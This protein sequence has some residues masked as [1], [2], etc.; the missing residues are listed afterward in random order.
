MGSSTTQQLLLFGI[1]L[2][3][4]GQVSLSTRTLPDTFVPMLLALVLTLALS[5][6]GTVS[7]LDGA[8]IVVTFAAYL[9]F[10]HA[11]RQA[12]PT[13]STL[14]VHVGWDAVIDG[15]ILAL[16][17]VSASLLLSVIQTVTAGILL[18]GSMVGVLTLG[19]ASSFPELSTVLDGGRWKTPT[20]DIGALIGSNVVNPLVGIRFGGRHLNV[21]R[22]DGG[23]HL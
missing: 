10:S 18:G 22:P 21:S 1:L 13:E 17:L 20:I 7:R 9:G 11:R 16:V 19:I 23:G 8:V 12:V 6:D 15:V 5:W 2:L 14:S 3:S 4:F